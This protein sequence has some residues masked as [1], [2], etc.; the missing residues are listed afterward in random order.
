MNIRFA[1]QGRVHDYD[2]IGIYP[3]GKDAH[4]YV[5]WAYATAHLDT[6]SWTLNAPSEP[7][8]YEIGYLLDNGY[9]PPTARTRLVVGGGSSTPPP[10]Q[11]SGEC[12]GVPGTWRSEGGQLTCYCTAEATRGGSVWGS[13]IY[14][15]DSN[16]CRAAVHAGVIGSDGGTVTIRSMGAHDSYSSTTR[17]GVTTTSY[18]G[19]PGSFAFIH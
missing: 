18:G 1:S 13:D 4:S 11:S 9:D 12:K 6:C 5:T 16:I 8:E 10:P 15:D 14:T 3:V 2:W 7:G 19:W 17:N